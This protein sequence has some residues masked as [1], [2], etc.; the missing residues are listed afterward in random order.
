MEKEEKEWQWIFA[1]AAMIFA[2]YP[3]AKD[4]IDKRIDIG[5][6]ISATIILSAIFMYLGHVIYSNS[7]EGNMIL[8]KLGKDEALGII[9]IL[10]LIILDYVV[11]N[12]W[13][14]VALDL[15]TIKILMAL[16]ILAASLTVY[17]VFYYI[18]L[19]GF[20]KK[21]FN[22]NKKVED[23][24]NINDRK[25]LD[26]YIDIAKFNIQTLHSFLIMTITIM[27]LL[28]SLY[29]LYKS[30]GLNTDVRLILSLLSPVI[31]IMFSI[32]IINYIWYKKHNDLMDIK[33]K[34][35]QTLT[36]SDEF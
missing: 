22:I 5:Y 20:S 34:L 35:P 9:I 36:T 11:F 3:I 19:N 2:V 17:F 13:G 10:I 25:V 21:L 4:L 15:V 32:S 30:L 14:N 7:K 8:M 28:L 1:F 26:S 29:S 18:M 24:E 31:G 16:S 23:I 33:L 6:A 27:A 12:L